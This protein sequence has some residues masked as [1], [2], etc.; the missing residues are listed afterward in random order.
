MISLLDI[1]LQQ[2]Y[3][4]SQ[5]NIYQ[6]EKGISM[7]SPI[8]G[9][10]AEIFLQHFEN[11]HLNQIFETKNTIFYTRYVDDIL[12]IYDTERTSSETIHNYMSKMRPNLEF[13][14]T[15]EHNNRIS[16]LDLLIIRQ[17]SKIET[18]I[19]TEKRQLTP[20]LT[21]LVTTLQNTKLSPTAT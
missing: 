16:F 14:P 3:F 17:P 10:V 21:S 15:Q 18:D 8:S 13:I 6:P 11:S 9:I 4:I 1:I 7:G 12:I 20:P 2:N 19:Y 5:N